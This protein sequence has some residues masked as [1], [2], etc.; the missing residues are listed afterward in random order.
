LGQALL[1]V[2]DAMVTDLVVVDEDV[3]VKEA[4]ERMNDFEIGCLHVM[5][6][7]KVFGILTERD[8]LKRVVAEGRK[9]EETLVRDVM[10]KPL[11]V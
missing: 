6:G 3:S 4:V 8:I 10:S 9:P 11:V 5:S 1:K 2:K 7:E